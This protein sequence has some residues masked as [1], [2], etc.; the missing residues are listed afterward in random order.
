MNLSEVLHD[1]SPWLVLVCLLMFAGI[2]IGLF[3]ERG[4]G[5]GSHPF[6]KAGTGGQLASDLPAESL[7]RPE[8]ER[9]LQRR[10]RHS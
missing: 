3:T 6:T 2:V 4:S 7:G 10:P 1:G 8:F 9:V 5:I